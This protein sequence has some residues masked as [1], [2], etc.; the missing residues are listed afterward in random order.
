MA[1]VEEGSMLTKR[2]LAFTVVIYVAV[3]AFVAYKK[4]TRPRPR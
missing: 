2:P 1:G 3:A 4:L